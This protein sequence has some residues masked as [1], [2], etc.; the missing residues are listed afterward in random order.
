[1]DNI[2]LNLL[3]AGS[4]LHHFSSQLASHRVSSSPPILPPRGTLG[5]SLASL[6]AQNSIFDVFAS[7]NE[8]ETVVWLK[9]LDALARIAFP[10]WQR[11]V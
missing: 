3:G 1:M 4:L 9:I 11:G 8:L 7:R 10:I 2:I 5:L 6:S